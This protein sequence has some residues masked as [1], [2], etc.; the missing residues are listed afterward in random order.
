[1]SDVARATIWEVV[2]ACIWAVLIPVITDAMVDEPLNILNDVRVIAARCA[3]SAKKTISLRIHFIGALTNALRQ[4]LGQLEAFPVVFSPQPPSPPPFFIRSITDPGP[5]FSSQ[6]AHDISYVARK[7]LLSA[8]GKGDG[9][10]SSIK[11]AGHLS[12]DSSKLPNLQ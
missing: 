4:Q 1:M 10:A 6:A 2:S 5:G 12:R 8:E 7:K 3:I 9:R 11:S